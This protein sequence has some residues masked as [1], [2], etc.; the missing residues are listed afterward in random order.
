MKPIKLIMSAFGPYAGAETVD[1]TP[2]GG[3]GLFLVSGVTGAGKTTIFDGISYALF[4]KASGSTRGEDCLRSDFAQPGTETFVTLEFEHNG[5]RYRI[6]RKPAQKRLKKRGGGETKENMSVEFECGGRIICKAAEVAEAVGDLLGIDGDQFRQ[7]AMIAQGEFLKLLLAGSDD[8]MNILGRIFGTSGLRAMQ[9]KLK[10]AFLSAR[11]DAENEKTGALRALSSVNVPEEKREEWEE[12][13]CSV[14]ET[15]RTEAFVSALIDGYNAQKAGVAGEEE[16]SAR[17]ASKLSVRLERIMRY[18]ACVT[19]LEDAAKRRAAAEEAEKA[20]RSRLKEAESSRPER[21]ESIRAAEEAERALPVYDELESVAAALNKADGA[22][23][24]ARRKAGEKRAETDKCEKLKAEADGTVRALANAEGE[25]ASAQLAEESARGKLAELDGLAAAYFAAKD[26]SDASERAAAAAEKAIA[27]MNDAADKSSAAQ[28]AFLASQAG[29]LALR[30]KDGEPCPVCGSADHPLPARL[31]DSA[32]SEDEVN[33]LRETAEKKRA[34]AQTAARAA[35]ESRENRE[36]L[37]APFL[38]DL[39]RLTGKDCAFSEAKPVLDEA[40]RRMAATAKQLAERLKTAEEAKKKKEQAAAESAAAA[41]KAERLRAEEREAAESAAAAESEKARLEERAAGL[42]KG[43]VYPGAA[44][45]RNAVA[46]LRAAA[47][48]IDEALEAAEKSLREA[49]N[50]RAAAAADENGA[51][52][53]TADFARELG[54]EA[55]K[56]VDDREALEAE[57]RLTERRKALSR[58][59][60]ELTAAAADCT[61]ALENYRSCSRALAEKERTA[62]ALKNLSDVANGELAGARKISFEAYVLRVYFDMILAEANKRLS[63]MTDGRY[64]LVRREE[65]TDN[66]FKSGLELDVSD[67]WTGKTRTVRSL[68]GGESFKASLSL[69]LGLS[70]VVQSAAG[71][72]KL[73]TMFID[74]GFG[75]LDAES[76]DR[77]MDIIASLACGDR[78]VGIISHVDELK[79]RI[80][81]RITV[82]KGSRGSSVRVEA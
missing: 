18:N 65:A 13:S 31:S 16:E 14:Y 64:V 39:K 44:E 41:E 8:R 50:A 21:D 9:A 61:R 55:G 66:R 68:S 11:A 72:V 73:D 75:T 30:L 24:A 5:E 27:E 60:D 47:A 76:L 79:Q 7:I 42:K 70:D 69:A 82:E 57:K 22:A 1:F 25:Y 20:A 34:A 81:R 3:T 29:L 63:A 58:R 36:K 26:A 6:T 10:S 35:A 40:H 62:S 67:A 53:R 56:R 37:T 17:E 12:L 33:A 46:R 59:K 28:T 19:E 49:E 74:E 32:P 71:G 4:G 43:L 38:S 54:A 51:A 15:E 77:A 45:A 78:L 80:D 23:H 2:F 48:R 52:K